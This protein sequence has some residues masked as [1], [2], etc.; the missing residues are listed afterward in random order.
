[1]EKGNL[2]RILEF[3][4]G[5]GYVQAEN[6]MKRERF[7]CPH[8]LADSN[9]YTGSKETTLELSGMALRT[10]SPQSIQFPSTK[11]SHTE[12]DW[13]TTTTTTV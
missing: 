4:F 2:S 7:L 8:A 10:P 12:Q 6:A 5:H 1:M 3:N 11:T 13:T 9:E